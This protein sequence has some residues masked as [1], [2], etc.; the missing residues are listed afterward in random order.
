[1]TCFHYKSSLAALAIASIFSV[2]YAADVRTLHQQGEFAAAAASGLE[3]LLREP[4]NHE[5]RFLVADSL[6]RSGDT[7]AAIT[8]FETLAGTV[9]SQPAAMRLN[10]LRSS[11]S[12]AAP[13][14]ARVAL[15]ETASTEFH[16]FGPPT[17]P[18]PPPVAETSGPN[19]RP[20]LLREQVQ[21]PARS[22]ALQ[23][24]YELNDAGNYGAVSREGQRLIAQGQGDDELRLIVANSLAWS[25][26][27]DDAVPAYEA[28]IRTAGS[29][30]QI[31]GARVGL[32]NVRRWQ[33]RDDLAVPLYRAALS[34]NQSI[35]A[36][37]EGM[38]YAEREI[39]PKTTLSIGRSIDSSEMERI[40]IV[41]NHRWRDSTSHHLFEIEEAG[42]RDDMVGQIARQNELTVRYQ[43]LEL[44]L[45]PRFWLSGQTTPNNGLFGGVRLHSSNQRFYVEVDRVNWGQMSLNNRALEKGLAASHIGASGN[46]S[47]DAGDITGTVNYYDIS[48]GN[49]ILASSLRYTP[50]WRLGGVKAYWGIEAREPK[51]YSADYWAPAAGYGST[52]VGLQGDWSRMN[53]DLFAAAQLGTR[54][55]GDAGNSSSFSAGGRRWLGKD[56]AV[57]LKY[58]RMASQRDSTPYRANAIS[59]SLE[60]L[61]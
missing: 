5:L 25:G 3:N 56:F 7:T 57:G 9:Y 47:F 39:R 26:K 42:S 15:A 55:S 31:N 28:I 54:V 43:P 1:M 36:A 17:R 18:S 61:W 30:G 34:D 33:G 4:W 53:W 27:L 60:S 14:L 6:E 51:E 22:A 13:R 10:H 41:I 8:Q 50:P 32:G 45:K 20:S 38:S 49:N 46:L 29:R 48:D 44:P 23:A 11:A 24:I 12:T 59:L 58:W 21:L 37:R 16:G 52:Y 40:G 2:S 35:E 19:K